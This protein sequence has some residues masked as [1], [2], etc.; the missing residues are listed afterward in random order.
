MPIEIDQE[1][2]D[3]GELKDSFQNTT[4]KH[5]LA[6]IDALGSTNNLI[7]LCRLTPSLILK[8]GAALGE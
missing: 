2:K 4:P 6:F 5:P 3:L 7:I 8:K 1:S